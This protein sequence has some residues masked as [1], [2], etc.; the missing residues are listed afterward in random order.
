M[1]ERELDPRFEHELLD[2]EVAQGWILNTDTEGRQ[3]VAKQ[4][5]AAGS[6]D[7]VP[8]FQGQ[9]KRTWEVIRDNDLE[10]YEMTENEVYAVGA[11]LWDWD[12]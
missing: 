6:T 3:W 4:W 10:T 7:G 9:K 5:L 8:H 1:Y 11:S 12:V 2:Q